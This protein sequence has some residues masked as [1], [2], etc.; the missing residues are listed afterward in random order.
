MIRI[1]EQKVLPVSVLR[2]AEYNPRKKLKPGDKI[3]FRAP[4]GEL[5]NMAQRAIAPE[6]RPREEY[7]LR[8]VLGPQDD[9]F[10]W[11]GLETFSSQV[12]TVGAEF[13]RTG[14]RLEGP[15][16]HHKNGGDIISDG[17]AFGAIQVPS[18]GTPIIMLGDRQ[19]TGGYTKIANVI[20]A[21]FRILAQLKQGDKVRFE[22]VSVKAAQDA[23][24][25][26]R[27]ALRTIRSALEA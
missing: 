12:Y 19:T 1:A 16:I 27:A 8:V 18:S 15:P 4:S 2:P 21:D 10:T 26:Q 11:E 20:T 3:G 22:K 9:C 14:C 17:I 13:D 6:F 23:L 7:T 5:R 25:T 24:L